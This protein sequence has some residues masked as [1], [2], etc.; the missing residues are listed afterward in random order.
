MG[1]SF[2]TECRIRALMGR[3]LPATSSS[4]GAYYFVSNLGHELLFKSRTLRRHQSLIL[5][6][7][8]I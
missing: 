4:V 8:K 6:G 1:G 5:G 7:F 2:G 3:A